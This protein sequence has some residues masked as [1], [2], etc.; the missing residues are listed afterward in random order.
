MALGLVGV[1]D[2]GADET[3][4]GVHR[5]HIQQGAQI[6]LAR[7]VGEHVRRIETIVDLVILAFGHIK[8]R[9]E[10]LALEQRGI[11]GRGGVGVGERPHIQGTEGRRAAGRDADIRNRRIAAADGGD[12]VGQLDFV[13]VHR[14]GEA[15]NEARRQHDAPRIGAR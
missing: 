8:R 7:Q 3:A 6:D 14:H 15:G 9:V 13:V 2:G 10:L 1:V 11:V 5:G 12:R 4:D